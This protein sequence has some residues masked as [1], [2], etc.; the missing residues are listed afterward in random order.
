MG[1]DFGMTPGEEK[2][3]SPFNREVVGKGNIEFPFL[4]QHP[5]KLPNG[6]RRI[7]RMFDPV[8]THDVIERKV[9]VGEGTVGL[10]PAKR[11]S[12]VFPLQMVFFLSH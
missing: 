10:I 7:L 4:L 5:M 9:S 6:I 2:A 8:Q 12:P 3:E 1:W 11:N